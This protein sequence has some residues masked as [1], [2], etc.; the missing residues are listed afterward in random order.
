MGYLSSRQNT[1]EKEVAGKILW[2]K[3][4]AE[5][6]DFVSELSLQFLL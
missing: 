1:E 4:L 3:E 6:A 2:N 5:R